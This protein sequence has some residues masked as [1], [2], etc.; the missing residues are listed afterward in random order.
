MAKGTEMFKERK[1]WVFFGIPWTFTVYHI[2]DEFVTIDKG[3]FTKTED[4]CYMY[5]IKDV[6]LESTLGERMFK[7]GTVICYTGDT[8]HPELRLS[9]IKHAKQV[10]DY[11]L[12]QSESERLKHRTI[13]TMD[14][15]D[16]GIQMDVEL[17][18]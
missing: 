9:H 2:S 18:N 13:N 17:D 6:K 3:F 14:I 15:G 7:L 4:D 10:K 1:R 8:T 11:I 16:G 12:T 5:K